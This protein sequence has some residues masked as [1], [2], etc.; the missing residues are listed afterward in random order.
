MKYHSVFWIHKA[1]DNNKKSIDVCLEVYNFQS[2]CIEFFK[3]DCLI[4]K[5]IFSE[6][7]G[8]EFLYKFLINLW[9]VR[10]SISFSRQVND[11]FIESKN[12]DERSILFKSTS[13]KP[14]GE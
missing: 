13:D 2:I 4:I 5:D 9:I 10:F 8:T 12:T 6:P 1:W 11:I 14:F 3:N 7:T